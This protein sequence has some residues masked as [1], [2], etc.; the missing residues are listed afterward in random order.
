MT[1]PQQVQ[2]DRSGGSVDVQQLD[3]ASMAGQH[4]PDAF[5]RP[6]DPSFQVVRVQPMDEEQARNELVVGQAIQG[7]RIARSPGARPVLVWNIA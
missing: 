4:R 3:V 7:F 6:N 5:Q 1:A 2:V